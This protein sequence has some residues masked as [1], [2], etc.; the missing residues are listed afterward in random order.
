ML[1]VQP[2]EDVAAQRM[3]FRHD[4]VVKVVVGN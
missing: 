1:A 4:G 3:A 2:V